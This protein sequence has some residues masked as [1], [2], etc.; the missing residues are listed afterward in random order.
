MVVDDLHIVGISVTPDKADA[1]LIVDANAVLP[2][3]V[4]FERFQ[5]ITRG[6][7]QITKLRGNIQLPE[8]PLRHPLEGPKPL[9]AQPGMK[10][11]GLF[12]PERLN[13]SPKEYNVYRCTSSVKLAVNGFSALP[14]ILAA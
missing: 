3:A 4:T 7:G 12:Q 2:S 5:V 13:H 11:L 14:A 6:R 8:F 9:E 1:P 10:Q